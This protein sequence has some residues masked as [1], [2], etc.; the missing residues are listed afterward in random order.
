MTVQVSG[1]LTLT[2]DDFQTVHQG[3]RIGI[4]CLDWGRSGMSV[5]A[6][7]ELL[8]SGKYAPPV[9]LFAF[10]DSPNTP[11]ELTHAAGGTAKW[12]KDVLVPQI[13]EALR[14]RFPPGGTSVPVG[15]IEDI[16]AQLGAVLRW[17]PQADGTLQVT[18]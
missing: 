16:D 5:I 11:E 4:K 10:G 18:A 2:P 13:N 1:E 15:S 8:P 17:A 14:E 12:I 3:T 7:V 9:A 6:L